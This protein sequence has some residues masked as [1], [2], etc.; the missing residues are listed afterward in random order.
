MKITSN[1]IPGIGTVHH[2]D[3]RRGDHLAVIVTPAGRTL[4][5]YDE[6]DPDTPAHTVELEQQ[7]ADQLADL[8]RGCPTA[9][10]L[11]EV[12]RRLAAVERRLATAA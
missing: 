4:L 7:E 10:R 2:T 11:T 1:T 8:L 5:L 9:D 12:E 6:A 3:T